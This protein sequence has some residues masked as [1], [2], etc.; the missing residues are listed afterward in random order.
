M[1]IA[2][3]LDDEAIRPSG[4]IGNESTYHD[5]AA[6]LYAFQALCTKMIP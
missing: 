1:R 4:E 3:Q 6:E 2:I 5:L